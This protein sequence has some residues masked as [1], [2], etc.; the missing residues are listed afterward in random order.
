MQAV[1]LG[2]LNY[3]L[4]MRTDTGD[5]AEE[6]I[7]S[8]ARVI[9]DIGCEVRL[10]QLRS[11]GERRVA[12]AACLVGK[13]QDPEHQCK[14]GESVDHGVVHIVDRLSSMLAGVEQREDCFELQAS[15]SKGT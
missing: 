1:A 9:V 12:E 14:I 11:A 2:Q 6:F 15:V 5:I 13:A 8:C 10:V 3:G 7:E 4:G